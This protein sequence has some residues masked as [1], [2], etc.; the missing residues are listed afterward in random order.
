MSFY[1]RFKGWA[2]RRVRR[3]QVKLKLCIQDLRFIFFPLPAFNSLLVRKN[4]GVLE[5]FNIQ[6]YETRNSSTMSLIRMADQRCGLKDFDW[7]LINSDDLDVGS[8]YAGLRCFSYCSGTNDFS[9][10]CPDFIF[11]HWKQ[12]HLDDYEM[13]R[14]RMHLQ[15]RQPALTNCLGW[16][17]ADTHPNRKRLVHVAQG[18]GYD[19]QFIRWEPMPN[20]QLRGLGFM[21]LDEQQGTWR[22]LIDIEGRGYS[23]R[24]KL[25]LA[26]GRVVFMQERKYQ[27]WYAEYLKPWFH[28]VPVKADFSDLHENLQKIKLNPVLEREII[29]QANDFVLQ[30]LTRD[31]AVERWTQ[32]LSGA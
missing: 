17:G 15:G 5:F 19:V 22:Y 31:R 29:D 4:L 11:D 1:N 24:L 27:E 18:E 13:A 8:T 10:A 20:G 16:R 25:L 14:E 21:S 23:G 2:L 3:W 30:H 12:T 7:V 26:T 6:E 9:H 32:L 28:Y